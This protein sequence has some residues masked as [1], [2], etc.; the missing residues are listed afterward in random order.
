MLSKLVL[1][2][3]TFDA[4]AQAVRDGFLA[5][6][7]PEYLGIL[8]Q[9]IEALIAANF[10]P[11]LS[12]ESAE[13]IRAAHSLKG[14]AGIAQLPNL[15]R[16]A[17]QVEEVLQALRKSCIDQ[18]FA[19]DLLLSSIAQMSH[20]ISCATNLTDR[21]ATVAMI[22]TNQAEIFKVL[23]SFVAQLPCD[24]DCQ[25]QEIQSQISH[26][27]QG[28]HSISPAF[29][30]KVLTVDL[31]KCLQ[32]MEDLLA[33]AASPQILHQEMATLA[34]ECTL[35]GEVLNLVWLKKTAELI[36]ESLEE[37][38][39]SQFGKNSLFLTEL[40]TSAI[41]EIR[42]QRSQFLNSTK[43]TTAESGQ[44]S[45][46]PTYSETESFHAQIPAQF[47]KYVALNPPT[48]QP[49]GVGNLRVSREKL[50]R[51]SQT[52]EELHLCY[53][54]FAGYES[55]LPAKF[56]TALQH[57]RRSLDQLHTELKESR[58]GQFKQLSDRFR[59]FLQTLQQRHGKAV[60]LVVTGG[61]IELEQAILESLQTPLTHLIRNAFDH[62]IESPAQRAT[63]GKS[64]TAKIELSAK[65]QG[66]HV[67]IAIA[68]DGRG[69]NV[70][71]VYQQAMELGLI[72]PENQQCDRLT[73]GV[74]TAKMLQFLFAPGFSTATSVS[75]LSGRGVGLD[76]VCHQ[77]ARL[78]GS[79]QVETKCGQGTTFTITLPLNHFAMVLCRCGERTLALPAADI[80]AT[81]T[82]DPDVVAAGKIQWCDR[83]LPVF[84]LQGLLPYSHPAIATHATAES[85]LVG[86]V[87]DLP[88]PMV[89]TVDQIIAQ[90]QLRL[91]CFDQMVPVPAYL[92]GC[93]TLGTGEI[94][95]VLRPAY[96][97]DLIPP[98]AL[99]SQVS[100]SR[101]RS[102]QDLSLTSTKNPQQPTVLIVDDSMTVRH[103]L[104][105]FFKQVNFRVISC[106]DGGEALAKLQKSADLFDLIVSD[107]QM[108]GLDGLA[109][110]EKIRTHPQW[111]HLPVVILTS[112]NH[113]RWRQRALNLGVSAYL[114]K[115]WEPGDLL[116]AIAQLHLA[117]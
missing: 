75:D 83:D 56:Q 88:L 114:T 117:S 47:L 80:L 89:I 11:E 31:E 104:T 63:A 102:D 96:L 15:S 25:I 108:P 100:P 67:M 53:E 70:Q 107:V 10:A 13:L 111:Q 86:L 32:R 77:I 45:P 34:E 40:A 57:F 49:P 66:T 62:G 4:I 103:S 109:F 90:R 91:S 3:E 72:N 55:Q 6:E 50:D 68:D 110:L 27:S 43:K 115:P 61:E 58:L 18:H 71:K 12:T 9:G 112:Q 105:E 74:D 73:P 36:A 52:L 26:Q 39:F 113:S 28:T 59:P 65:L 51:M 1:E 16:F 21:C 38:D 116:D 8:H 93:T 87:L 24:R 78:G 7:A 85:A 94:V 30:Q 64:A 95:P 81:L 19:G 42:Q 23:D 106:Q 92:A 17:H 5:E 98:C 48:H 82:L 76:I 29:I 33:Q 97:R 69:I 20:L 101:D 2:P 54:E 99:C 35:L 41:T 46:A 60:E 22:E 44:P 37:F 79:M 14:G 84:S